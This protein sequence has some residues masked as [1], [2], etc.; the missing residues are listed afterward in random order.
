MV[1]MQVYLSVFLSKS[2]MQVVLTAASQQISD[3]IKT[4]Y[5]TSFVSLGL[6]TFC[7][8]FV[9]RFLFF[10]KQS[11]ASTINGNFKDLDFFV[12]IC[13]VNSVVP[14]NSLVNLQHNWTLQ[15]NFRF[16]VLNL[17]TT[18]V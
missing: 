12:V 1:F 16:K 7:L 2:L 15:C 10:E 14:S 3:R 13:T 5:H 17:H 11:N 9:F 8:F 4:D 6:E 18:T